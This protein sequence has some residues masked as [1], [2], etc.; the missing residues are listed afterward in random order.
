[1]TEPLW[2]I[3]NAK[4]LAAY[5]EDVSASMRDAEIGTQFFP[6]TKQT[7]LTLSWIR[8]RN[9]LPIALQPS[10]F[11]TKPPLRDRIGVSEIQTEMP[12]FREGV[13]V[14]E[15]DRQDIGQLLASGEQF[16]QPLIMKIFDDIRN[17]IDGALVQSERMRMSL[18]YSGKINVSADEESGRNVVYE[19][20]YDVDGQWA[21]N[22]LLTLG[23]T[24]VWTNAD[25]CNPI[26]DLLTAT[27]YLAE[28]KGVI[29]T[30]VLM[31]TATYKHML[32]STKLLKMINPVG[33]D[34][35]HIG[36]PTRKEFLQGETGLEIILYDKLFKDERGKEHKYYPDGYVTVLPSHALGNTWYGTTPEEYD[37]LGGNSRAEVSIVNT[38][39]AVTTVKEEIPVNVFTTVSEIVLPSFERMDDIYVIKVY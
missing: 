27:E 25:N 17:L 32:N 16:A 28:R 5:W 23:G 35:V 37:L 4:A 34:N 26:E 31:N 2:N 20:N 22:Q 18:L 13:R 19:Y 6:V 33:Y 29:A 39:V 8:G 38:G 3:F 15:K 21:A 1:M 30:R 7:G 11:D 10:A 12:F 24:S 9:N 14:G 36:R